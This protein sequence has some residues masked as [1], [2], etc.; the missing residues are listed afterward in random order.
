[1]RVLVVL[2]SASPGRRAALL[3]H[4]SQLPS[5]LVGCGRDVYLWGPFV[6]IGG[7]AGLARIDQSTSRTSRQMIDGVLS[8][9]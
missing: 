9:K 5:F 7:L 2:K 4:L 1:M 6:D 3:P 8:N